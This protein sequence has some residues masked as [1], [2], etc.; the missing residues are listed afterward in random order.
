MKIP[1]PDKATL[2]YQPAGGRPAQTLEVHEFN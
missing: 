2:T 1:G